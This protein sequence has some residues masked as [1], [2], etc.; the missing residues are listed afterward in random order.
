MLELLIMDI[1]LLISNCPTL[2]PNNF[3][4]LS[5]FEIICRKGKLHIILHLH[6]QSHLSKNDNALSFLGAWIYFLVFRCDS[7]TYNFSHPALY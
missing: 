6:L 2:H 1:A 5:C 7:P 4:M 3:V